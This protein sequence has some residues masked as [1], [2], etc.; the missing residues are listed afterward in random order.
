MA[1]LAAG[2][3]R[4]SLPRGDGGGPLSVP[5]HSAGLHCPAAQ[6]AVLHSCP[7]H[8]EA[9]SAGQLRG[10]DAESEVHAGSCPEPSALVCQSFGAEEGRL[11]P[12]VRAVSSTAKQERV[13]SIG[14]SC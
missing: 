12:W 14:D 2:H 4:S 10:H 9:A 6:C 13:G 3:S 7:S 8:S 11:V 1:D 5:P